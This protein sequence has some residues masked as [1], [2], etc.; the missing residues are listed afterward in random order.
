VS[1][2][3][4]LL[5]VDHN[6]TKIFEVQIPL[7]QAVGTDQDI[8]LTFGGALDVTTSELTIETF[9]EVAGEPAR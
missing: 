1:H 2:A 4:A 3:E 7:Q 8:H 6:Q 5:F 9:Y